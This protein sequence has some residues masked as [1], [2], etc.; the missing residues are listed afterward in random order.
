[1]ALTTGLFTAQATTPPPDHTFDSLPVKRGRGRPKKDPFAD[2]PTEFQDS[3]A[4]MSVEELNLLLA[5]VSKN[6]L[7]NKQAL[8][9]DE[10]VA[11]L[12]EQLKDAQAQYRETTKANTAKMKWLRRLIE[13]KGG[14]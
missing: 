8:K 7:D 1:M 13:D 12:K 14:S 4:A 11:E 5:E 3:T 6:E 2:V 10:H 9:D